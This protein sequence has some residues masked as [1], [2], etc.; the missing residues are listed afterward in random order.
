[1]EAD[2][3]ILYTCGNLIDS[4]LMQ[5]FITDTFTLKQF[6]GNPTAVCI[7]DRPLG[8]D[9]LLSVARELN[10]PVTAFL[11]TTTGEPGVSLIRYFTVTNEIPA[12]GHATLAAAATIADLHPGT[13]EIVFRTI[14]D[15]VIKAT[16]SD[17][18]VT[19]AYPEYELKDFSVSPQLLECL[20]I[21]GYKT[22]GFCSELE[23]V[24]I[25]L[26][27]PALLRSVQPDFQKMLASSDSIKEVVITS[28]SDDRQYDFLL[29]SFCP[30][31][32]IDEDPVTGSV[33]S[34][35]AGFW[36][37]KLKKD[38]LKAFQAS[39][40]GGE[41][42]VTAVNSTVFIA[43]NTAKILTGEIFI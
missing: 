6:S 3:I 19:L 30:W 15:V 41:V 42:Y 33:H 39:A 27:N 38:Q 29:R 20:G 22:T 11:E 17:G 43:G 28:V 10:L 8:D 9:L 34:V 5:F 14:E 26:D 21:K 23:T 31:I 13:K 2:R 36:A 4:T 40:R 12:C 32:G 16:T 7:Q 35:L 18:L 1:V 37:H 24:F 25:E